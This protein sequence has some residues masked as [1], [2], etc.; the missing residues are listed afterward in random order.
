MIPIP[1][2]KAVLGATAGAGFGWDNEYNR[3]EV[4]VEA[5]SI[6]KYKVSNGQYLEFVR[7][8]G[9]PPHFWTREGGRWFYRGMFGNAPLPLDWP[10]Y[11]SHE[12]ACAYAA[13]KGQMEALRWL[14]DG[15]CP[16]DDGV[17]SAAAEGG[18]EDVL[19]YAHGGARSTWPCADRMCTWAWWREGSDTCDIQWWVG[20][21][22]EQAGE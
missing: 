16:W 5:F 7:E 19:W 14:R 21:G 8:G 6:G 11:V 18:H 9:S 4:E 3:H 1:A 13:W 2:G 15:G 12:Q 20:E 10:V 22:G 17:C